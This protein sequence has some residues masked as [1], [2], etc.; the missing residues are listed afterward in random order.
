MTDRPIIAGMHLYQI[1]VPKTV[2]TLVNKKHYVY[3][4][5]YPDGFIAEDGTDLSGITFYVGVGTK[6][7]RG[8]VQRADIHENEAKNLIK[9]FSRVF[10]TKK[11]KVI[12]E[13][14]ARGMQV[15]KRVILESD[16]RDEAVNYEKECIRKIYAG[17]YLTNSL[18][19]VDYSK[20]FRS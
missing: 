17:P 16:F 10:Y 6:N 1:R 2:Y 4:L 3:R 20:R 19:P 14:W 5:E 11:H 18:I 7:T 13:I 9:S 8:N 15:V 12:Y